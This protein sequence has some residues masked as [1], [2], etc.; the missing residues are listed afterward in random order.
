M[1]VLLYS[2]NLCTEITLNNSKEETAV[3]NLGSINLGLHIVDGQLDQQLL[4]KTIKT[5]MRMLD[6]V[7]DINFIQLKKVKHQICVI[8]LLVWV[9]WVFRMH[10]L[11]KFLFQVKKTLVLLI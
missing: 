8:D 11:N 3:C 2:S 1:W 5:A 7:I 10:F 4:G 6:N 9:L